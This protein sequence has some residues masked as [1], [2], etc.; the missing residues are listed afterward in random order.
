MD[1]KPYNI[2]FQLGYT[3]CMDYNHDI[4]HNIFDCILKDLCALFTK[5]HLKKNVLS[6]ECAKGKKHFD[7]LPFNCMSKIL[8]PGIKPN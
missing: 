6:R 8:L 7:V 5:D 1:I 3:F 4:I 2:L